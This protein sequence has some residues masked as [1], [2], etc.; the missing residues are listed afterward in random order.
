MKYIGQDAKS[1]IVASTCIDSM[2]IS[3]YINTVRFG[4]YLRDKAS[5]VID[6]FGG[7]SIYKNV[8]KV[9]KT[10]SGWFKG[11]ETES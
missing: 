11:G 6:T 1:K 3:H 9:V 2:D 8:V 5:D 7:A 4:G 10:V